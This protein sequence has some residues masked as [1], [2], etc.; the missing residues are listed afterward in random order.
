MVLHQIMPIQVCVSA[1]FSKLTT[2]QKARVIGWPHRAQA[3]M[4]AMRVM[5]FQKSGQS[6]DSDGCQPQSDRLPVTIQLARNRTHGEPLCRQF[7]CDD[8]A[9]SCIPVQGLLWTV[10]LLRRQCAFVLS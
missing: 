5:S 2:E 7:S 1:I 8:D 9:G 10:G 4:W 6:F 3:E